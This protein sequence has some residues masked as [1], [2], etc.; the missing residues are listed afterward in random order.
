MPADKGTRGDE[1]PFADS[2]PK[3]TA[4]VSRSVPRE[5]SHGEGEMRKPCG[6]MTPRSQPDEGGTCYHTGPNNAQTA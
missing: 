2:N 5:P 6:P 4:P 1:D 3:Q